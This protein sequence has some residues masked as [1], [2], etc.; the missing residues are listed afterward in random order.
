[1]LERGAS[2]D[3]EADGCE[4]AQDDRG[5]K[6]HGFFLSFFPSFLLSFFLGG[7]LCFYM[8]EEEEEERR[9]GR[10]CSVFHTKI[11]Q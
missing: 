6:R 9:N 8:K 7:V 1:M 5:Q 10:K 2:D 4:G 3:E 11:K